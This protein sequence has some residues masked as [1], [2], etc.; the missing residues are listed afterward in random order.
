[1]TSTELT[2]GQTRKHEAARSTVLLSRTD[3]RP[4]RHQERTSVLRMKPLLRKRI[5]KINKGHH[6]FARAASG[7]CLSTGVAL[8]A[9]ITSSFALLRGPIP[10]PRRKF[11]SSVAIRVRARAMDDEEILERECATLTASEK[12]HGPKG[13]NTWLGE[14]HT[15]VGS[16]RAA[17]LTV[18]GVQLRAEKDK[19][20]GKSYE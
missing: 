15:W 10:L 3:L 17:V 12:H 7:F 20:R 11:W 1:L 5:F 19:T 4:L 16:K 9:A 18:T 8:T 14:H 13:G 6:N 2:V